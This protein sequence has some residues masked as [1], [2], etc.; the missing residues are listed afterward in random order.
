MLAGF[1]AVGF[2]GGVVYWV[3]RRAGHFQPRL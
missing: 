1:A 3:F 2:A